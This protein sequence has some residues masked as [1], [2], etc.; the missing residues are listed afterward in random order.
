MAEYKV[1]VINPGYESYDIERELL[2][3][4]GAQ[5]VVAEKDCDTEELI[6]SIAGDADAILVREGPV[7]ARVIDSLKNLKVIA[8][9]EDGV[10]EA[11]ERIDGGFGLFV[12]WH[13]EQMD[14]LEHRNAIYGAL[15]KACT[16]RK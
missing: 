16:V 5:V 11:M 4:L 7:T 13:P 15:I 14:N 8:N 1:V 2:E 3:P 12:Q 10:I 9:S 6:I